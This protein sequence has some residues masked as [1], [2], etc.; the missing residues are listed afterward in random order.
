MAQSAGFEVP[1]IRLDE[2]P[3]NTFPD[4][5]RKCAASCGDVRGELRTAKFENTQKV[6]I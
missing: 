4:F 1:V 6:L 5:P 2:R 3:E